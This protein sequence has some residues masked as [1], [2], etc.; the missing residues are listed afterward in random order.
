MTEEELA[1]IEQLTQ[2]VHD[3]LT[4]PA[5]AAIPEDFLANDGVQQLHAYLVETRNVVASF[6]RG[7]FNVKVPIKGSIGG[8]LKNLQ[9]NLR[10]MIWQVQMVSKGDFSQ[11]VD[12]MGDFSEAFNKMVVQMDT[13]LREL[14][15]NEKKL[16]ELTESLRREI[17]KRAEMEESLR[18]S[19][20]RYQELALKDPLTGINNRRNFYE[21]ASK[22][23]R[24]IQRNGG[25]AI[26]GMLDVDHFKR[27]NDSYGHLAGDSCLKIIATSLTD[28]VREI[29]T[30]GR[31]GGEEFVILLPQTSVADGF[32]V[33]ERIRTEIASTPIPVDKIIATVTVSI[34]I[35]EVSKENSS[36]LLNSKDPLAA[37][38]NE[39][40]LALYDAKKTRNKVAAYQYMSKED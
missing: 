10:H 35:T 24:R 8:L 2:L 12:F 18:K 34:G 31:Y 13:T 6:S 33:A 26:I 40:D 16:Q 39:A 23:M 20:K 29:D 7:D 17:D 37:L 32:K 4:A 11:R 36:E 5:I 38:I 15:E 19:H 25:V 3:L 21:I 28:N 9:A 22:E 1:S 14:K 30:V 27:F